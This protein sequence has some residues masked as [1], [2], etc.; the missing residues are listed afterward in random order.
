MNDSERETERLSQLRDRQIQSRDPQKKQRATQQRITQQ[1]RRTRK[2]F[3][4]AS[5]WRDLHGRWKGLVIGLALGML[6]GTLA[7]SFV[8]GIWGYALAIMVIL[9]FALLGVLFGSSF[10]WRDDLHDF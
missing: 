9:I 5:A 7:A 1:Y 3:T 2:T 10:D 6:A 8:P 4:L